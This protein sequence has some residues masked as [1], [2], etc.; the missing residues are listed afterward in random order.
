M[1]YVQRVLWHEG[2]FLTPNHF[3][4]WDRFSDATLT[5]GLR[6]VQPLLRGFAGL[7]IDRDTLS[8]ETFGLRAAAGCLADGTL[9]AMPEGDALPPARSFSSV[10]GRERERLAVYLALPDQQPGEP[11]S[12]ESAKPSPVPVRHRR[13][14]I[15]LRDA[16][17][18][19]AERDVPVAV[20][21]FTLRFEGESLDGFVALKIA[22]ITRGGSGGYG[23]SENYLATCVAWSAAPGLRRMVARLADVCCARA[24]ELSAQRRQR[25]A[26]MVEFSVSEIANYMLLHTLNGAI[27]GILHLLEQPGTHP[28]QVYLELSRLAG[29]LHTF[30]SD[31]HAKDL[32]PYR[33]DDLTATFTT[34]EGIL[35]SLLEPRISARYSGLGMVRNAGGIH[36]TK[37]PE[38]VLEGHRLYLAVQSSAAVEKVVQ[39][40]PAKA[41][42]AAANR[43]PALIAQALKGL[44][45]TYLSV[46]P[47]EIAAQ[48]GTS[49]FEVQR[50]GDEW[51][52]VVQAQSIAAYLPPDFTDLRLEIMAVKE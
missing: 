14:L 25:T 42:L 12:D 7:E 2:M 39:Q 51:D 10:F 18:G 13:R 30:A 45:L 41:K 1:E 22:E 36:I 40:T 52:N 17:Y 38:N 46:P 5:R 29:Q 11:A 48:P 15:R 28:E 34:L 4:Q 37:L 24:S 47:G 23:L 9:F 35:R 26:G 20:R 32:P 8:T 43:V 21:D 31:G 50:A 16:V 3:Q 6:A 19:G 27:P 44:G 33:H 49:Y